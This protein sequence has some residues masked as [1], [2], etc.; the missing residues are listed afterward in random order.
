M[1]E[2]ELHD[3]AVGYAPHTLVSLVAYLRRRCFVK[4]STTIQSRYFLLANQTT[5]AHHIPYTRHVSLTII[6]HV[7]ECS[8]RR[9]AHPSSPTRPITHSWGRI[10]TEG[11]SP[12][13]DENASTENRCSLGLHLWHSQR[14]IRM[15]TQ[16]WTDPARKIKANKK[17]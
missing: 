10:A 3:R 8:S 1:T 5:R 15:T 14:N 9:K 7:P 2:R 4:T 11:S 12:I 6:H 16:L 13:R 17:K